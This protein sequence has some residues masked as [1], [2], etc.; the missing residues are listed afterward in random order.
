MLIFTRSAHFRPGPPQYPSALSACAPQNVPAHLAGL[1]A[2]LLLFAALFCLL[3][4]LV[5]GSS[6][7]NS[8]LD[9]HLAVLKK[10]EGVTGVNDFGREG[11]RDGKQFGVHLYTRKAGEDRKMKRV[12]CGADI[13][14]KVDAAIAA[15]EYVAGV[16]GAAALEA[17]EECVRAELH[18]ASAGASTSA[19]PPPTEEELEWLASWLDTQPDP[20]E[21]SHAQAEAALLQRRKQQAGAAAAARLMEAQV[22]HAKYRAAQLRFRR[23]EVDMR[24]A[25]ALL[26]DAAEPQPKRARSG[27]PREPRPYEK[28][29][30]PLSEF[31][32]QEGMLWT[33]RRIQLSE[34]VAARLP[35]EM[36]RGQEDGPMH[37]WRRGL[38]FAVQDWAEGS[39]ADAAKL[40]FELQ[41][42]TLTQL[43]VHATPT[44]TV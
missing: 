44:R 37:H 29:S 2:L 27:E 18:G 6:S 7:G 35:E 10:V 38:V 11:N 30:D 5:A 41:V 32:R 24:K 15:K 13:P 12:A 20:S 9:H 23:A 34:G 43:G 28:W 25:K 19:A 26:P 33:R 14:T 36:P 42:N 17:A 1:Y 40:V 3:S 8:E 16:L 21:I 39:K 4:V 31:T 22:L